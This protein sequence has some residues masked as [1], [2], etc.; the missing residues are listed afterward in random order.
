MAFSAFKKI[1]TRSERPSNHTSLIEPQD[2]P[3]TNSQSGAVTATKHGAEKT[4]D[5]FSLTHYNENWD[6][7]RDQWSRTLGVP[8]ARNLT[9]FNSIVIYKRRDSR[10]P[11]RDQIWI[12]FRSKPLED[13][14]RPHF[15]GLSGFTGLHPGV[16]ARYVYIQRK[17]LQKI[18]TQPGDLI[19]KRAL[20][21]LKH[22]LEYIEEEFSNLTIQLEAIEHE[23]NP[24][25]EWGLLWA[26]FK[27]DSLAEEIGGLSNQPT[28]FQ[29]K[30]WV[31]E[32]REHSEAQF[33]VTGKWLEWTGFRYVDASSR[34]GVER[35]EG[36]RPIDSLAVKP[37]S[38]LKRQ[39]LINRGRKYAAL[40]GVFHREYQSNI[41]WLEK[42][43][44]GNDK[45]MRARAHGR[46]MVDVLSFRRFAPTQDTLDGE[47]L[48][49]GCKGKPE[50]LYDL[51]NDEA[52]LCLLPPIIP[53]WSFAAKKWGYFYVEDISEIPFSSAA[54]EDLVLPLDDK[55]IVRSLVEAQAE[56]ENTTSLFRDSIPGKGNGLVLLLYGN[57]G[58]GKTLTAEAVS[59][60]LKL[61]LYSVSCSEFGTHLETVESTLKEVL[62]ITSLWKAI[63]LIDEADIFLEARSEDFS[64]NAMVGVFLRL[65]EYHSGIII[66]TTNRVRTLDRAFRSRISMAIKYKDLDSPS[67]KI[68]WERFLRL[69]GATIQDPQD[70]NAPFD[71]SCEEIGALAEK[72]VNGRAIK[73]IVRVSQALAMSDKT[74][75][76]SG[77]ISAVWKRLDMLEE[78]FPSL[79]SEISPAKTAT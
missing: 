58:T 14:L 23:S 27:K 77:H 6:Y 32:G 44:Q 10:R 12:E 2:L 67:R 25:I 52:K 70:F 40:A 47:D 53:G 49:Q 42:D 71:F 11:Y 26:L 17:A 60:Y 1:L 43:V 34:C 19:D 51:G 69:A 31:Y 39:E 57:P 72:E 20:K 56:N 35:Y 73:H 74:R 79:P 33:V 68:L 64:R 75:V 45:I 3:Q 62:D 18:V 16:D 41:M 78:D 66:F 8:P 7:V 59:E 5:N 9:Q 30:S 29:F 50:W 36:V 63:V 21:E 37:L 55:K 22:L 4:H 76:N 46:I 54:F 48:S 61:P 28:A 15:H 24:S 13:L 38:D 65:L